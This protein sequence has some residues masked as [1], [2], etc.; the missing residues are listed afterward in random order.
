MFATARSYLD[1]H[2]EGGARFREFAYAVTDSAIRGDVRPDA[3][4]GAARAAFDAQHQ[5]YART[6]PRNRHARAPSRGSTTRDASHVGH[7]PLVDLG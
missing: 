1:T 2:V 4:L 3:L 6:A 7:G 5:W